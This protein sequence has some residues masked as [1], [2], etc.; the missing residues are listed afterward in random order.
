MTAQANLVLDEAL[1]RQA[2]DGGLSSF[3]ELVSR[4][5]SRILRFVS[6]RCVNASD[7]QEVTQDIFVAAFRGLAQF[8]SRRSFATWLFTI[9]RRKC[10]DHYRGRRPACAA[11][12]P[13]LADANDPAAVLMQREA[14]DDVWRVARAVL[15]PVQYDCLWLRYAEDLP[16]AEVA[17]VMRRTRTHVKVLL[18]RAR[19]RLNRVLETPQPEVASAICGG[20]N[21]RTA[22]CATLP[23]TPTEPVQLEV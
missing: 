3:E 8:D 18:F 12:M 13:E 11:E 17:R 16:V 15:P 1:A 20:I 4:Y 21:P 10:I 6:N 14:E 19:L 5:E 2:R 7:A 23:M 9:A 22:P